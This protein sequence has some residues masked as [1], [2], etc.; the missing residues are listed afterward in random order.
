LQYVYL[1]NKNKGIKAD[2]VENCDNGSN[3]SDEETDTE[4][5]RKNVVHAVIEHNNVCCKH[6][7]GE[8]QNIK[9]NLIL[10]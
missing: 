10:A 3:V 8:K 7:K 6:G 2:Y 9:M 1:R 4:Y 5:G